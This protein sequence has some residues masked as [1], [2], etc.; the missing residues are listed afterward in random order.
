MMHIELLCVGRMKEPYYTAA[1]AE[2]RKRL[3][4]YAKL[5]IRELPEGHPVTDALPHGVLIVTLCVEG[6]LCSSEA[7]AAKL[8]AWQL[9]GRSSL[10]FIIGGSDGLPDE[11]KARADWRLSLSPMT[12]PHHLARVVVLEQLYRA[13]QINAGGKYHK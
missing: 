13:M 2:Y 7:L 9:D 6:E 8:A 5:T 10:C 4:A 11:V 1:A 12:F 3:T